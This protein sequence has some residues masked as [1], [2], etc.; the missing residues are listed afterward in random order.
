MIDVHCRKINGLRGWL[1]TTIEATAVRIAAAI[2]Q[3]GTCLAFDVASCA[4]VEL[5]DWFIAWMRSVV[6]RCWSRLFV[7]WA[8]WSL[9][10]FDVDEEKGSITTV[11]KV[12][13]YIGMDCTFPMGATAPS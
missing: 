5:S 12:F 4:M 3:L 6:S 9:F 1:T 11:G 13:V 8:W 10:V 2:F 7:D